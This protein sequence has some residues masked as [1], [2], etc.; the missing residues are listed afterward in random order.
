MSSIQRAFIDEY[1]AREQAFFH[2]LPQDCKDKLEQEEIDLNDSFLYGEMAFMLLG[3]KPC[4]LIQ[5][6]VPGL[7]RVYKDQVID[8]M[9]SQQRDV[10]AE[11]ITAVVQSPELDDMRGSVIVSRQPPPAVFFPTDS[12]PQVLAEDTLA[13]LLDYPGTLPKVE[14][15]LSIMFEI[16]Y[17]DADNGRLLTTFVALI[18]QLPRVHAHFSS[19]HDACAQI[20][21]N[22]KFYCRRMT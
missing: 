4:V 2:N 16:G 12:D 5:F 8:P 17:I 10:C 9:L 3:L 21:L 22:L 18:H 11:V 1:Y 7:C 19:Y 6:P 13:E 14:E 15:E 20:N